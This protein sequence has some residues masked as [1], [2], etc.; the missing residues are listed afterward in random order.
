MYDNIF[1]YLY[2][3]NNIISCISFFLMSR[4]FTNSQKI[5]HIK[6]SEKYYNIMHILLIINNICM[7]LFFDILI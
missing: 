3:Y 5:I 6:K 7:I 4:V 2:Y 1:I